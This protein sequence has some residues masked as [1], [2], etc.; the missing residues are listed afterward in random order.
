LLRMQLRPRYP[1]F[2]GISTILRAVRR[3]VKM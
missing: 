3:H 2:L 1:Y